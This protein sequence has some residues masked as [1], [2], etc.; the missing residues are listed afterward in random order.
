MEFFQVWF[1]YVRRLYFVVSFFTF[2]NFTW[3]LPKCGHWILL[4]FVSCW[5]V[6]SNSAFCTCCHVWQKGAGTIYSPNLWLC[7]PF[8]S[9][10]C[11]AD[12][13]VSWS[14]TTLWDLPIFFL[15]T[16]CTLILCSVELGCVWHQYLHVFY[17]LFY[18]FLQYF[19]SGFSAYGGIRMN[20]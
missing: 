3:A 12:F 9:F 15:V 16:S 7:S 8:S 11:Q 1:S 18:K 10:K 4:F 5:K 19:S 20:L 2:L 17:S 6:K 13:R 14:E